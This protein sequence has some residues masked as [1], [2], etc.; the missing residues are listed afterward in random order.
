MNNLRFSSK[1][2]KLYCVHLNQC[3]SK[4]CTA[5]KLKKFKLIDFI[6]NNQAKSSKAIILNPLSRKKL[7]YEDKELISAHGIIIIDCSWKQFSNLKGFNNENARRLPPLIAANPVNYGKW[8]KL[9]SVEALSA[10]LYFT[11]YDDCAEILLSKFNWGI[12]FKRLNN[13]NQNKKE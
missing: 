1:Y 12:E 2:P 7:S 3:D 10:A 8:N 11:G 9:S 6:S 4:K 13:L 5:L